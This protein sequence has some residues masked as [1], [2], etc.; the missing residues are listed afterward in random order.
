MCVKID[1]LYTIS[2]TAIFSLS[3]WAAAAVKRAFWKDSSGVKERERPVSLTV[4]VAEVAC[5]KIVLV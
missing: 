5:R 4:G 2:A 1:F 3:K